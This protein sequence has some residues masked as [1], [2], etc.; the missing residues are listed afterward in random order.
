MEKPRSV[1]LGFA[2]VVKVMGPAGGEGTHTQTHVEK[3]N[4]KWLR[5]VVQQG[6]E[7]D[8]ENEGGDWWDGV[9]FNQTLCDVICRT[10]IY[11]SLKQFSPNFFPHLL[12]PESWN[13]V[14]W[15]SFILKKKK[16]WIHSLK[17]KYRTVRAFYKL[18]WK[19]LD[20]RRVCVSVCTYVHVCVCVSSVSW[21]AALEVK[22]PVKPYIQLEALLKKRKCEVSNK[23]SLSLS[24]LLLY[25]QQISVFSGRAAL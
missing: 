9:R 8:G 7:S 25:Q 5:S 21:A 3:A 13:S 14:Q 10:A 6:G 1:G 19:S 2:V 20:N 12:Y 18:K 4:G 23:S 16:H 24:S 15:R 11:S 17:I 22:W